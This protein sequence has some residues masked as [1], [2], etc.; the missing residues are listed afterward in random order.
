MYFVDCCFEGT[1]YLQLT[2]EKTWSEFSEHTLHLQCRS[3][4][5]ATSSVCICIAVPHQQSA[6]LVTPTFTSWFFNRIGHLSCMFV[7]IMVT[8]E[9]V[10]KF[11]SYITMK[12]T[13]FKLNL[14]VHWLILE[15]EQKSITNVVIMYSYT[16]WPCVIITTCVIM[17]SYTQVLNRSGSLIL[18]ERE[19]SG[20]VCS[21]EL[22][23]HNTTES[24]RRTKILSNKTT[25]PLNLKKN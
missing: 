2:S 23:K 7:G 22:S 24:R 3:D 13:F 5:Q 14:L 25:F 17:Y 4:D 6:I 11:R 18:L 19:N 8:Q 15:K 12:E 16:S 1:K 9:T 21:R 10:F 20:I